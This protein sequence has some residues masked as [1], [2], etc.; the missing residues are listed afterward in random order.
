MDRIDQRWKSNRFWRGDVWP[1][2]NCQ[3]ASGLAA[4]WD[5][6]LAADITDKTIP[7]AI[8][9]GISEHYD[10]ISGAPLGIKDYCTSCALVT[11]MLDGLTQKHK[12]RLRGAPKKQLAILHPA[13]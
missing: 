11:M 10:S 4:H 7:N 1:P 6:D 2:P 12:V 3:I 9:N 13:R 5:T 8:K